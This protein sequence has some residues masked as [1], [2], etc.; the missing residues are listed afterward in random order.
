[1]TLRWPFTFRR[2]PRHA[3]LFKPVP[4]V[5]PRLARE[6]NCAPGCSFD[7]GA[8]YRWLTWPA[9][10]KPYWLIPHGARGSMGEPFDFGA[11]QSG[12]FF[13]AAMRNAYDSNANRITSVDG[14]LHELRK[15]N[16]LGAGTPLAVFPQ[17]VGDGAGPTGGEDESR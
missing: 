4:G 15:R 3:I 9:I 7:P 13:K 1:M 10:P 17:Q 5:D 12:I 14:P 8:K 6:W 11:D 2:K 16:A